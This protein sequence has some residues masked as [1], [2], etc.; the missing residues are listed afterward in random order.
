MRRY[1]AYCARPEEPFVNRSS[2]TPI[3]SA[4]GVALRR[5]SAAIAIAVTVI[6][7]LAAAGCGSSSKSTVSS[8]S[9]APITKAAF[10]AKADAICTKARKQQNAARA[11]FGK[12]PTQAQFRSYVKSTVIPSAQ[13]RINAIRAVGEPAGDQATITHILNVAQSDVNK[14]KS[15][16]TLFVTSNKNPFANIKKLFYSY[17]LKVCAQ[18]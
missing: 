1:H 4:R 7:P 18:K 6:A 16:V 10:V 13:A 17:G 11:K 5:R 15:N 2:T 14:V 9:S 8:T 12:N 3:L